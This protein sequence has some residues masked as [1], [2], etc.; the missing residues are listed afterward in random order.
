MRRNADGSCERNAQGQIVTNMITC[1]PASGDVTSHHFFHLCSAI[2]ALFQVDID[3]IDYRLIQRTLAIGDHVF[4]DFST[5]DSTKTVFVMAIPTLIQQKDCCAAK[6]DQGRSRAGGHNEF[7][8]LP[9]F[10]KLRL[11]FEVAGKICE[12]ALGAGSPLVGTLIRR[13]GKVVLMRKRHC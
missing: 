5:G 8:T 12:R 6:C 9:G 4:L 10:G 3:S 2:T 13:I 11:M 7:T 1:M